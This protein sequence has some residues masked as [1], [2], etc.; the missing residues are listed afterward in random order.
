MAKGQKTGGRKLGTPN[1]IS[2]NVKE[3]IRN[4]VN[5]ELQKMP[6]LLNKMSP[7]ERVETTIKLLPYLLPKADDIQSTPGD[8][9]QKHS[10]ITD[11]M[12]KCR[13]DS[14]EVKTQ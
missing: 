11:I 14:D 8:F 9:K 7:K 2:Y 13:L 10:F 6:G 5:D 4:I 3:L 1:R 12:N